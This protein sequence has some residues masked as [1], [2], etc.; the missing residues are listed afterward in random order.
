MCIYIYTYRHSR[1]DVTLFS[2]LLSRS[3]QIASPINFR[4][5]GRKVYLLNDFSLAK[6]LFKKDEV[7]ARTA[8]QFS[9]EHRHINNFFLA[10][11]HGYFSCPNI[12]LLMARNARA[13]KLS[14]CQQGKLS[15]RA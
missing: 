5:P 10:T 6:E 13:S 12:N 2:L 3:L 14:T 1:Q 4:V 8:P 15:N 7:S 9:L 11:A